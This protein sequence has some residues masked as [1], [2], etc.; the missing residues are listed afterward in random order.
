MTTK[1]KRNK[2]GGSSSVFTPK[3][4]TKCTFFPL[5]IIY[6]LK[7]WSCLVYSVLN[8]SVNTVVCLICWVHAQPHVHSSL[9]VKGN[10]RQNQL[11][12]INYP[13]FLPKESP[14]SHWGT[15]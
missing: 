5:K 7:S 12:Q 1:E 10:Q 4:I 2:H 14:T 9:L 6:I 15:V 13:P 8:G 3:F 11:K